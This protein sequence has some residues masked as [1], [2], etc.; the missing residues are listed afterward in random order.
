[1]SVKDFAVTWSIANSLIQE[2]RDRLAGAK[3]SGYAQDCF[4]DDDYEGISHLFQTVYDSDLPLI[5]IKSLI[6]N[7]H[8]SKW[9]TIPYRDELIQRV[10]DTQTLEDPEGYRNRMRIKYTPENTG[11]FSPLVWSK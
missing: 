7:T 8:F 6:V 3:L 4:F 2:G 10:L 9:E 1:M 5:I 11:L